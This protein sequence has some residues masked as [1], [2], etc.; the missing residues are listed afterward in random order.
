ML[1]AILRELCAQRD[2]NDRQVQGLFGAIFRQ[3]FSD[4]Q[5]GAI[6]MAWKMKKESP[7]EIASAVQACL[8]TCTLKRNLRGVFV[9]SCGTG[10]DGAKTINVSTISALLVASMGVKMAK[11]G[12][13]SVSS[14]SGSAD[15]LEFLGLNIQMNGTQMQHCLKETNFAFLFAPLYYPSFARVAYIRKEL[16]VRTIFNLLGPLINPLALSAQLLGVYDKALCKPMAF[17][18][19]KLGVPRAMVVHT[20]GVDEIALHG[21]IFVCE[22]KDGQIQEYTLGAQDFGLKAYGL[23]EMSNLSVKYGAQACL[24]I[25]QGRGKQA[26]QAIVAANSAALLL[27][28]GKVRDLKEGVT[29][30]LAHMQSQKAYENLQKMIEISHG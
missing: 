3:E 27:L 24:D 9:D 12:N 29:L 4:A 1:E 13:R 17:A 25:L 2:L 16:K 18:L 19:Q 20:E 14:A 15:L 30:S 6:L 28:S 23:Q 10:G 5:L 21:T 8:K 26:H 22:L 7:Q 11:H